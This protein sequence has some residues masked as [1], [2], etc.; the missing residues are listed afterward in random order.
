[1]WFTLALQERGPTATA[2]WSSAH[3]PPGRGRGGSLNHSVSGNSQNTC[4]WGQAGTEPGSLAEPRESESPVTVAEESFLTQHINSSLLIWFPCNLGT[5]VDAKSP[6]T[7]GLWPFMHFF[8]LPRM[9]V[10]EWKMCVL[11]LH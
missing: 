5:S 11:H 2:S 8:L 3:V 7:C 1:M 10:S 6:G 4:T 9:A